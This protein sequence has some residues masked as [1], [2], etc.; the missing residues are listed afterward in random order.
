ML[1]AFGLGSAI[2]WLRRVRHAVQLPSLDSSGHVLAWRYRRWIA[3]HETASPS[4]EVAPRIAVVP[5]EQAHE[6]AADWVAIRHA[7]DQLAAA[8][9]GELIRAFAAYP[10]ADLFYSD[11]DE[12]DAQG[13]RSRPRFKPDWSPDYLRSCNYVGG[14]LV[15]RR[16]LLRQIGAA[17]SDYDLVLKAGERA[18]RIVH[19][20]KVLYHRRR[21]RSWANDGDALREHLLR[22]GLDADLSP[23]AAPGTFRVRYRHAR[24]P[25]VSVIIPNR[26]QA[27]MLERCLA[28]FGENC[29]PNVEIVIVENGSKQP[30][31][32]ALYERLR[33]RS[34]VRILT[35]NQP[36][37]YAAVNNFA[38]TQAAGDLL[39]FLNNDIEAI[40]ADW[41]DHLVELALLPGAGAVGAKLLY[42]DQTVQHGGVVIG[43]HGLA[44]HVCRFLVGNAPG[45]LNR[46]QLPHNVA[47]VTGACLLIA[48]GR[49]CHR[50]Q[51]YR[52]VPQ[53]GAG[54]LPQYLDAGCGLDPSRIQDARRGRYLGQAEPIGA[55]GGPGSSE[56]GRPFPDRRPVLRPKFSHGSDGLLP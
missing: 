33:Q 44:G 18:R 25:R 9:L 45:Y 40:H 34:N 41:L 49:I 23:R 26:D 35:W 12:M 19:I 50:I 52:F 10:E 22:V 43:M 4:V 28:A 1:L 55:R 17:S 42:P 27:G 47:A 21:P 20:P 31:T 15:V 16:E 39:L 14:L 7:D 29:Y 24:K 38:V 46:L 54:R 51:R 11:E 37:N 13:R 32:F 53:G 8:A 30:E 3:R 6:V 5:L 2:P 56:M 48:R 36:F